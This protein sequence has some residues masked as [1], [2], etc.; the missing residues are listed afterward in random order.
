[1]EVCHYDKYGFFKTKDHCDKEH[2]KVICNKRNKCE[3][4]RTCE[5]RHPKV[6]RTFER[7]GFPTYGKDCFYYQQAIYKEI[8]NGRRETKIK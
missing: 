5:K 2:C 8:I 7:E 6:C 3:N 1:M 4:Y